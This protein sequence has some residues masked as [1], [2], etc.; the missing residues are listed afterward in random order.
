MEDNNEPGWGGV[1]KRLLG[2]AS[3]GGCC[4]QTPALTSVLLGSAVSVSG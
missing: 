1:G 3:D 2:G 4:D